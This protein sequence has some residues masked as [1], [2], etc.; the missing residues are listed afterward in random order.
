[1]SKSDLSIYLTALAFLA[2]TVHLAI[3]AIVCAL[4]WLLIT[5]ARDEPPP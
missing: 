3:A 2:A 4:V 5:S 1:M